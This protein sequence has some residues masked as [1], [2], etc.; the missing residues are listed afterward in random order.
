MTDRVRQLRNV[1]L[2][3][4]RYKGPTWV[5]RYI[6]WYIYRPYV[7]W[8]DQK[9][10]MLESRFAKLEL[11]L[12]KWQ[13]H[14]DG[15]AVDRLAQRNLL[16]SYESQFSDMT[17]LVSATMSRLRDLERDHPLN[18]H[19]LNVERQI[20]PQNTEEGLHSS[21]SPRL[22][23]QE[24]VQPFIENLGERIKLITQM[25][26]QN[27]LFAGMVLP[28][29]ASKRD[30]G[31]RLIGSYER[32]LAPLIDEI[33]HTVS[34]DPI[35]NVGCADGFYAVGLARCMPES[36][37]YA[38]DVDEGAQAI[39][40]EAAKLNKVSERLKVGGVLT[41]QA[42]GELVQRGKRPFVIMDC[43]GCERELLLSPDA[44]DLTKCILLVECHDFIDRTITTRLMK[45]F[46]ETHSIERISQGSR[47]PSD[48]PALRGWPEV[49]K[50]LI[51]SENRPELMHWLIMKPLA[52]VPR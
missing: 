9:V 37:V 43:E 21:G 3:A 23:L 13:A 52:L 40:S 20:E 46:R 7:L 16:I 48:Y 4:K 29:S 27:G 24:S 33:I 18:T 31:S 19:V 45:K 14:Y 22:S 35:I 5:I 8:L 41:V 32:E 26:V 11:S 2:S 6:G 10:S 44:I 34:P 12:A 1:G 25:I 42:L 47:D 28:A 39:C 17:T 38:F 49:E 36:F 51:L 30:L 15:E 50:W